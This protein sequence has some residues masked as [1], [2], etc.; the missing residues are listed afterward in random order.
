MYV[1]TSLSHNEGQ[2]GQ[3]FEFW[4]KMW[5]NRFDLQKEVK[6]GSFRRP[7]RQKKNIKKKSEKYKIFDFLFC[8]KQSVPTEYLPCL[9]NR[10]K[11]QQKVW[12]LRILEF[13]FKIFFCVFAT[14]TRV[15]KRSL[16]KTNFWKKILEISFG[17]KDRDFEI[18]CLFYTEIFNFDFIIIL[19]HT[20]KVENFKFWGNNILRIWSKKKL[21]NF[22]TKPKFSK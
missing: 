21:E 2:K 13:F 19:E 9:Q 22:R 12:K 15:S 3:L 20:K 16:L 11:R 17:N 8:T 18:N 6:F 5:L 4:S 14:I 1:Y 7:E 10:A